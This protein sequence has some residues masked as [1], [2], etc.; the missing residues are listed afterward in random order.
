MLARGEF[1]ELLNVL[2][3]ATA[4]SGFFEAELGFELAGHH[5]A[6]PARFPDI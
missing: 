6:G 4:A 1:D 2:G 5:D 3:T